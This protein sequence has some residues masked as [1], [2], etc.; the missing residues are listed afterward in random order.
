MLPNVVDSVC[1][2]I[3]N[4][5]NIT[6]TPTDSGGASTAKFMGDFDDGTEITLSSGAQP[7]AC[8]SRGGNNYFYIALIVR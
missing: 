4:R 1:E 5:L 6:A 3:N 8:F 2:E 7:S